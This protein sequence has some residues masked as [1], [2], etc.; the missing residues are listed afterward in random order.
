MT[1]A[2][3]MS[4][5][6]ERLPSVVLILVFI[7][8]AAGIIVAGTLYY[9]NYKKNYRLEVERQLSAIAEL[10]VNEL[11]RYRQDWLADGAI[12]YRNAPF[13]ALVRRHFE[14]PKDLDARDQLRT[15]LGRMTS[16]GGRVAGGAGRKVDR[17][18][19]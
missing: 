6:K 19:K 15:W 1:Q 2:P 3:F 11:A 17:H 18:E 9:R 8:L 10:K 14:H 12:F 4:S 13:A 7:A 16:D 5:R